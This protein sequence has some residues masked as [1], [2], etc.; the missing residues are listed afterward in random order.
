MQSFAA[1]AG[2]Q[3][4][5]LRRRHHRLLW[6]DGRVVQMHSVR[7]WSSAGMNSSPHQLHY[8]DPFPCFAP[9]GKLKGLV[10]LGAH[11]LQG[12]AAPTEHAYYKGTTPQAGSGSRRRVGDRIDPFWPLSDFARSG[13]WIGC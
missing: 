1:T 11:V 10:I 5:T 12:C 13:R 9:E 6:D 7:C 3:L 4:K 8:G 2:S